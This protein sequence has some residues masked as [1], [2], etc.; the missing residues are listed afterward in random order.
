MQAAASSLIGRTTAMG[1]MTMP[2]PLLYSLI[3]ISFLALIGCNRRSFDGAVDSMTLYSLDGD[4]DPIHGKPWK[5]EMFHEHPVLGKTDIASAADRRAILAAVKQ[6]IAQ[7]NGTIA[8]C[9]WPRHGLR[10]VQNGGQSDYVIC[11][12]CLQVYEYTDGQWTHKPTTKYATGL[13]D[14]QLEKADIPKKP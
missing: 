8:E 10:L 14:E 5:G 11:F 12:E 3:V 7:S 9:F 6:G 13:L 4:Y 2:R 1:K